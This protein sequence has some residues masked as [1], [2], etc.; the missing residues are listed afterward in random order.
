MEL[1]FLHCAAHGG[2][3][4]DNGGRGLESPHENRNANNKSNCKGEIQ[5]FFASLR[6][7]S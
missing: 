1:S 6:M 5:G 4:K 2:E 3:K 7:T